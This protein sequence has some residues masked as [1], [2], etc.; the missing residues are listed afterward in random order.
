MQAV[1]KILMQAKRNFL[2]KLF[3]NDKIILKIK[4]IVIIKRWNVE[5]LAWKDVFI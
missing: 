1:Y 3:N 4:F 2:Q 5:F